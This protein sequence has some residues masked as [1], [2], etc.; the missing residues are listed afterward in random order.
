VALEVPPGNPVFHA[1]CI[2]REN[3][4]PVQLENRYVNPVCAPEFLAQSF[5]RQ[6]PSEYLLDA[7]PADEIEHTVDAIFPG[8]EA[9][10]LKLAANEP[11]LL[12]TRR[13]WAAG[14]PVTFV[15]LLYPASRYR[16]SCRFKPSQSQGR[17]ILA[18]SARDA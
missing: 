16:L 17:T 12:L 14:T 11:C 7:V 4:L 10:L 2:H 15:R 18:M 5:R 8:A 1:V 6:P 9:A 13:T 3:G